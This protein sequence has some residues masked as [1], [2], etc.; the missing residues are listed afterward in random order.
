MMNAVKCAQIL[1]NNG[2]ATMCIENL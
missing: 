2:R 1:A